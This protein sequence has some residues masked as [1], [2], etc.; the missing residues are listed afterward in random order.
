MSR[1]EPSLRFINLH[2]IHMLARLGRYDE[3]Y[4]AAEETLEQNGEDIFAVMVT[5]FRHA[6]LGERVSLLEVL[7]GPGRS[8]LWN[9]PEAPEWAAGWLALVDEKEKA[10]DWLDHW[11][12]RGS[13]N[14][15]MLAR[16]DPLLEGLRAEP[17]F[18]RLLDRI[19]PE[20]ERFTPR[21]Q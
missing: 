10:L 21:F 20:W 5:A 2:R 7:E 15:P 8:Y 16:G 12:D 19:R 18:Q 3:A 9:D 6:L 13:I 17:R 1:R 14:Y 11:I 4:K